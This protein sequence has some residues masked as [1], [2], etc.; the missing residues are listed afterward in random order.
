MRP[1]RVEPTRAIGLVVLLAALLAPL[2]ARADEPLRLRIGWVVVPGHLFPVV[3][4]LRAPILRHYGAIYSVEPVHFQGSAP[5]VTA[6]AA[7]ELDIANLAYASLASAIQNAHMDDVRVIS[8]E[9]F[10]VRHGRQSDA[11]EPTS[12]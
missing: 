4:Q 9:I 1:A 11:R 8:V 3:F 10:A 2:T 7:G 6:L 12:S 5:Q